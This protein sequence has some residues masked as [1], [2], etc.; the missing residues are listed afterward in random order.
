VTQERPAAEALVIGCRPCA[1]RR[2][3]RLQGLLGGARRGGSEPETINPYFH[4]LD[5]RFYRTVGDSIVVA[6]SAWL[7]LH[8]WLR[9]IPDEEYAR[10]HGWKMPDHPQ[11]NARRE[12]WMRRSKFD[13][14]VFLAR[15]REYLH[16]RKPN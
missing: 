11:R 5:S 4:D 12:A 3:R 10:I 16:P 13:L 8:P 15:V 2:R 6:T 7:E 9:T 1:R 14:N